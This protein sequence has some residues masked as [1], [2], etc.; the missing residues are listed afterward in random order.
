[1]L[2]YGSEQNQSLMPAVAPAAG[3]ANGTRTHLSVLE[4]F[5]KHRRYHSPIC[6]ALAMDEDTR[7]VA[8]A[9]GNCALNLGIEIEMP[10]GEEPQPKLRAVRACNRRVCPFC[11][12]RR[13]K[14]LR[15]RFFEG[16]PRFHEDFPTHHPIFLTLTVRNVAVEDLKTSITDLHKAWK[17]M[18]LCSF[19]PTPFWFRKTEVTISGSLD[20]KQGTE[21]CHPHL[22]CLLMVPAGYFSHG[23]VK[24]S[25]WQKQWMMAARLD[26][27]PQVRVQRCRGRT[28]SSAD[29]ASAALGA[30]LE[31]SKYA[32]KAT[33]LIKLGDSLGEYHRQVRGVRLTGVSGSLQPYVSASEI[34]ETEL[35]D[36]GESL[37]V[38]SVK[39]TAIWFEDLSEYLFE[40]LT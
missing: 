25:E 16:L 32:A 6:K 2:S 15:R 29:G 17:R 12:W 14:A 38:E 34:S 7:D 22:H 37:P 8:K 1:M 19:F 35:T 10:D 18:T 13:T 36:G 11:E 23:Y 31:A 5:S 40:S 30:S 24:Q 27:A 28:G 3:A 33:D 20:K 4:P 39:G 21:S 26:Y 9:I